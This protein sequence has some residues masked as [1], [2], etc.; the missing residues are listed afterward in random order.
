MSET[1]MNMEKLIQ[2]CDQQAA[3][4]KTLELKW[5][6]GNDSG[7]VYMEC[8]GEQLDEDVYPEAAWLINAMYD[9]LDYGSWA[10]DFSASG[11]ASYCSESKMFEGVD[12]YSET[13]NQDFTLKTPLS[14]T[15]PKK[16]GFESI[17][18]HIESTPEE[19]TRIEVRFNLRNGMLHPDLSTMQVSIEE[20]LK[21]QYDAAVQELIDTAVIEFWDN[22][23]SCWDNQ[24][25]QR[26]EAAEEKDHLFFMITEITLSMRTNEE[27]GVCI[28]L[29]ELLNDEEA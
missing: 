16:Y 22:I 27:K 15:V 11:S 25:L 21:N 8:D 23:D 1:K 6:G 20:S 19:E 13:E 29:S 2:W 28:D 14:L 17:D 12:N 4:G 24:L 10:G 5:D 7:W 18:I 26:A 3:S 9:Q